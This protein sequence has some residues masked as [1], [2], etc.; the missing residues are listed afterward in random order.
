MNN[1]NSTIEIGWVACLKEFA[2]LPEQAIIPA[3]EAL[4]LYRANAASFMPFALD[5]VQRL[6]RETES[7]ARPERTSDVYALANERRRGT[8]INEKLDE[9]ARRYDAGEFRGPG[10][11]LAAIT[12]V[13]EGA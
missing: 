10:E 3:S 11:Y 5:R 13:T 6:D 12:S 2:I 4:A 1:K 8:T 7:V 9:L